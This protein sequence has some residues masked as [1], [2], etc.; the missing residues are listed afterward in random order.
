M[1]KLTSLYLIGTQITDAG[2][3]HLKGMTKLT[4]LYLNGTKLQTGT[5]TPTRDDGAY[6]P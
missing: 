5:R 4:S 3:T 6:Q 2:L 1:T